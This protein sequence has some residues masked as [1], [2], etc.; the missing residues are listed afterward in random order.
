MKVP[1]GSLV[2][3]AALVIALVYNMAQ[4]TEQLKNLDRLDRQDIKLDSIYRAITQPQQA[5]R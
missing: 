3:D 4:I 2:V 5:R 1:P